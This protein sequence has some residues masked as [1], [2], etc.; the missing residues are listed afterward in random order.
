LCSVSG[1]CNPALSPSETETC[2]ESI[3][4]QK[5]WMSVR[6]NGKREMIATP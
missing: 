2:R 4:P 6:S 3:L 5:V 1:V